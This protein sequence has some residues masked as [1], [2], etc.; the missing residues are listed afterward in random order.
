[1][2]PGWKTRGARRHTGRPFGLLL[3]ACVGL[4]LVLGAGL[5]RAD[6]TTCG[7]TGGCSTTNTAGTIRLDVAAHTGYNLTHNWSIQK[8]VDQPS[9]T[10]AAGQSATVNYTVQ[11]KYL[12]STASNIFVNDGVAAHSLNGQPLHVS[13]YSV[14]IQPDNAAADLYCNGST[15]PGTV[16]SGTSSLPFTGTDFFCQYQKFLPDLTPRTVTG[17]VNF[18]DGTPSISTTTPFDFTSSNEPG[19]PV[20]YDQTVDVSDSYAGNLGSFTAPNGGSFTY[21]RTITAPAG[22]CSNF[23]V[24]NTATLTD[25][26]T[27]TTLGTSDATVSVHVKCGCRSVRRQR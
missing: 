2:K 14:Q 1:M 27:G 4:A 22:S 17:T 11:V 16:G 9:L 13:S 20:V 21:Q 8:S 12:G 24:P 3:M 7:L 25:Q 5:A 23:T 6:T 26:A 19:Q 15:I 18:S 10:L